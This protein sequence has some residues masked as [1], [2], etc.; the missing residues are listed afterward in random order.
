MYIAHTMRG[1]KRKVLERLNVISIGSHVSR[2]V[3]SD[4]GTIF[5]IWKAVLLVQPLHLK[6]GDA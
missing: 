2:Y 3:V 4:L 1:R 6:R 5:P